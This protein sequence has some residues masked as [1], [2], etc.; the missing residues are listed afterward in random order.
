MDQ[1]RDCKRLHA[2]GMSIRQ[3]CREFDISRNTVRSYLRGDQT[4]G[5]YLMKKKRGDVPILVE[6]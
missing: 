2:G 4:P 5:L 3:L 6:R 1:I